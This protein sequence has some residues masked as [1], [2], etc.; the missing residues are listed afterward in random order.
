L[1]RKFSGKSSYVLGPN[2]FH[3]SVPC[4]YTTKSFLDLCPG[5]D[6]TVKSGKAECAVRMRGTK[7]FKNAIEEVSWK[8]STWKI[9][10]LERKQILSY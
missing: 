10:F 1:E 4:Q 5:F 3:G 2:N 7:T 6:K 9:G 8:A